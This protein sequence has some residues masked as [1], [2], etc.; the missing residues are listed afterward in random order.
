M[1]VLPLTLLAAFSLTFSLQAASTDKINATPDFS[2]TDPDGE[3]EGDGSNY[4]APVAISNSLMYLARHGFPNL[5]AT[6]MS[7]KAAQIDLVQSLATT[8][9]VDTNAKIG[10]T[11]AKILIGL[12]A[13]LADC[14]Y[15]SATL[16]YQGWRE[17]PDRFDQG[18]THP[19]LDWIRHGIDQPGG[20]VW[21]NVGWYKYDSDSDE[22][23]RCGGHWVTLV[24]Y[25]VDADGD[26][27]NGAFV[28]HNPLA[29][30]SG[31]T[32]HDI[33]Y[34]KAIESGTLTATGQ[35]RIKG[36][37]QPA[38]GYYEI[39]GALGTPSGYTAILDDA[40]TLDMGEQE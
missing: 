40:I 11:P 39:T 10:T 20:G 30:N 9:Y 37:P 5:A 8:D 19:D 31:S 16:E 22:Y 21:L 36:L 14:G 17:V 24:G 6:D 3:F 35:Y 2:Q 27:D 29:K 38:N 18:E 25:G 34:L 7:V 33:I 15:E 26:E 1:Q 4:C 28:I 13:Y 32:S 12:T 23:L